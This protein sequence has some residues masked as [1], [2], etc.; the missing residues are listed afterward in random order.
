MEVVWF[1]PVLG[2]AEELPAWAIPGSPGV[3]TLFFCG[4]PSKFPAL[5]ASRMPSHFCS[6]ILQPLDP[7]GGAV[8]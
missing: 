8:L 2:A 3:R 7:V 4:G 1:E 6:Q 5:Q